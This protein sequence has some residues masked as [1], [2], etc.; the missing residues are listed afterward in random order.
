MATK[1][2]KVSGSRISNMMGLLRGNFNFEV[3]EDKKEAPKYGSSELISKE[4]RSKILSN[5]YAATPR[6]NNSSAAGVVKVV[7][8]SLQRTGNL[9]MENRK[10]L[11]MM[12]DVDKAARLMVASI[13]SPND[14]S[15]QEIKINV[16]LD[17]VND[18]VRMDLSKLLSEWYQKKL[19]LKSAAPNW[20][21]QFGYES[22]ACVFGI[23]PMRSFEK[24]QDDSFIGTESFV[25]Q[26]VDPLASESLFGFSDQ[27]RVTDAYIQSVAIG[28]ES[29]VSENYQGP[30]KLATE[31]EAKTRRID[32]IKQFIG[33][34]ALNLTD[35]PAVLQA[36]GKAKEV[37]EKRTKE[38]LNERFRKVKQQLVTSVSAKRETEEGGI[39][40]NPMLMRFPPESVT[41]IHTPGD[42]NDHQGYLILLDRKG[43][44]IDVSVSEADLQARVADYTSKNDTLINQ[45]WQ[46]YGAADNL[47]G[48]TKQEATT[49]LYNQ[50]V[51][52]HIR[53]RLDSIGHSNVS[54]GNIDS[55]MRCMFANF[56]EQKQTRIL[57]LPKELV[58]Y[59]TFEMDQNGY[60]ISRL[61]GI[62]FNLGMKMA[63]Q[64]SRVLASI[65]AAADRRKIE[66]KFTDNLLENPETIFQDII[67][68][69]ISK[70]TM[71]FSIDPNVIQ[72]QIAEKSLSMKGTDIPG[73]ESFDIT[74]EPDQRGSMVDFDPAILE[75]VD[76][77]ITNG[78]HV[79][80]ATM[81]SLSEDEY[82]RSVV[83]TNLFFAMDVAID[84]E[85]VIKYVS[86]LLRKYA[87]YSAELQDE[88]FSI[89]PALKKKQ[90]TSGSSTEDDDG[91]ESASDKKK[92]RTLPDDVTID[93]IIDAITIS[94]PHPNV[95]PSK[96]QFESLEAMVTAITNTVNALVSDEMVGHD[97][98]LRP[99][100]ALLRSR[101]I[102]DNIREY[103]DKS[104]MST[105][106]IPSTDFTKLLGNIS[107]LTE[108]LQNINGLLRDKT[109]LVENQTPEGESTGGFG[110]GFGGD[111]FGQPAGDAGFGMGAPTD[112]FG[113]PAPEEPGPT[114]DDGTPPNGVPGY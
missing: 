7:Q 33:T 81:N 36:T 57:F 108:G 91:E 20:V 97:E 53:K 112:P 37:K 99:V 27:P 92:E 89:L 22:G 41:V 77:S 4:V 34:E 63:V 78:L 60:G 75:Y 102:A 113:S 85:I 17:N 56:M 43:N 46:A 45:I 95:A 16:D 62:K 12:P 106:D 71:S 65:K 109:K 30:A 44:P 72:N 73:V 88:I 61:E 64:I 55:V 96:A 82:A 70:S 51:G 68:A 90:D 15:R 101:I 11:Q 9:R 87:R 18:D 5:S 83:T 100:V 21:Y 19:N 14:L 93:T 59:M 69:H 31:S 49:E 104:G 3:R 50:V 76:K 52:E 2:K 25:K 74:N 86:D 84:Q 80:A 10:I 48:Y 111:T 24:I 66:V 1:P 105:L 26:V 39:V 67:Q 79:P 103:L 58:T 6:Q 40:G 32:L 107:D 54:L 38:I 28:L 35:N 23:I 110:G 13:F 8:S 114:P 98:S 47:R 42:P 29:F 94:L